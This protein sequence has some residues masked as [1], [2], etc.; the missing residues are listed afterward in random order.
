MNAMSAA[1]FASNRIVTNGVLG[2]ATGIPKLDP[3][4]CWQAVYS[5]DRRF[6]GRFFAGIATTG[7][8]CRP[9]CP[10]SFGHPANVR[11]FHCAEAAEAAGFRPCK[12][13]RPD[14]SPWSSA[15]FGTLAVVSN[16]L[17]LISEGALDDGNFEQ[18]AERVGLGSRHLRRLFDQH[19][20]ASPLKI[21]RSQRVHAARN[22]I[23]DTELAFTEIASRTGFRSIRQFNHAVRATF[24]RSPTQLRARYEGSQ[25]VEGETGIVVHLPYRAPF[26]WC[27]LIEFLKPRATPGVETVEGDC[28]RRTIEIGDVVSAIEVRHEAARA[29]LSMRIVNIPSCGCLMQVVQRVRRMFDL[30]ADAV[31][32]GQHLSRNAELAKMLAERPGLRVPGAWDGFELAVRAV[33]GQQLTVID[34][35]A[36]AQRLV[37]T[38]GRPLPAPIRG[39]SHLFPRPEIL[40]EANL[41]NIGVPA[42]RASAIGSLARALLD[43]KLTFDSGKGAR[44]SLSWLY[45]HPGLSQGAASYIAMRSFGEPDALPHTDRGLRQALAIH[46][47]ASSPAD[48]LRLF[49]DFKPWRAYAAMHYSAAKGKLS[50]PNK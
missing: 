11:W 21:A 22:R 17:K 19:L 5:R 2:P 20:G 8:Y 30:E 13:C 39:L 44:S 48:I 18:L 24:G 31:F 43:G 38:F 41:T 46:G 10:A 42:D 23:L 16:A 49:Q 12:R 26:D 6:D 15:W 37:Q 7:V 34:E 28:Y 47:R 3:R 35:P 4:F 33:L 1:G 32:I 29:R 45:S 14:T 36:L 9:I 25:A 50:G 40:A 27:S